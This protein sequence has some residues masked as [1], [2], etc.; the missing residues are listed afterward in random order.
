M[1]KTSDLNPDVMCPLKSEKGYSL[2]YL[3]AQKQN[4]TPSHAL[5]S[6]LLTSWLLLQ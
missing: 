1:R 6:L 2:C 5:K 4:Q 3:F